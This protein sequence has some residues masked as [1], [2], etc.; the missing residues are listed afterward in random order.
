MINFKFVALSLS[1]FLVEC[2][3]KKKKKKK[4]KKKERKSTNSKWNCRLPSW[5]VLGHWSSLDALCTSRVDVRSHRSR[6]TSRRRLV[7]GPF[8]DHS[9]R[10]SI[11]H[12]SWLASKFQAD[13]R[14][15]SITVCNAAACHSRYADGIG[16]LEIDETGMQRRCGKRKAHAR[17]I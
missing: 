15:Y 8:K 11:R 12:H 1:L 14:L 17:P 9:I 16:E 7:V 6:V 13:D 5:A 10:H 3:A 2:R 4:K